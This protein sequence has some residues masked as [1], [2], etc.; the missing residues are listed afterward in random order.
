MKITEF[1][2]E[3]SKKNVLAFIDADQN[4]DLYEEIECEFEEMLPRA[5]EKIQ[6]AALLAFGDISDYG[7]MQDG[8]IVTTALYGINSVGKGLSE[9]STQLFAEGDYLK[10]MLA[11]AMA[12]DYLFQMDQAV[13]STVVEMCR[14]NGYGIVGRLE[15]PQDIPI[16]IQKR[17]FDVT[18]A[19]REIGLKIKES[20]MYDPVKTVCQV[21][22]LDR[23]N[24]R[25]HNEHDCSKCSNLTCRMR[26]IPKVSV[27][28][29]TGG[30]ER[31]IT[32]EKNKSLLRTLQEQQIFLTAVCGGKGSCGKC[33]IRVMEGA[34]GA[35]EADRKCFRKEE[36]EEGYRLACRFYPEED[37]VIELENR[38]EEGFFVVTDQERM[39]HDQKMIRE[40][41]KK[42]SVSGKKEF[43]EYAI[44]VDIGST[45]IAMQLVEPHSGETAEVYTAINRQRAF[46]ADVIS[47]MEASNSG[48]KEELRQSIRKE[49]LTGIE[50]LT[51]GKNAK[52]RSMVI[53]AN[54]TMVH[55]LMGY[56][57]ETLGV[58]PFTPVN[59]DTIHTSFGELFGDMISLAAEG[60]SD[61]ARFAEED[62]FSIMVCPGISTYVGGDILAGMYALGF[63]KMEKIHVLIDLG[64]NGEMAVGNKDRI[65]VASTAAGPA[66]EGGN[67]ICGTG[68]IPGAICGVSLD[69]DRAKIKT[70]GDKAPTGI[71]GTGVIDTVY[72][73]MRAEIIDETGRMEDPYFD[74]GFPLTE[75]T[76][77]GG[78]DIRFYQKDVREIQLA[79]SAVRAGLETLISRYG[80]SYDEIEKIYIAGG[81]GYK[82]DIRKAAGIGLLPEKCISQ[83]A[84]D[85]ENAAPEGEGKIVAVGNSCL[86]GARKCL[87]ETDAVSALQYLKEHAEEVSLSDDKLFQQLYMEHMYFE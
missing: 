33:R 43:G 11:D 52:I 25:F 77:A 54:T 73:L 60:F 40:A 71:C 47:R 75:G 21:Y 39:D 72:E 23:N 86:K 5:Y 55:L 34:G 78:K 79:K 24:S 84:L 61:L 80:T 2:I 42:A 46:G 19:E 37:C 27:L 49:L 13:Q 66:F 20:F 44:A 16:S 4:S 68:S 26:K 7:I 57:C 1:H 29:K 67:I 58:F 83:E 6:P 50:T 62:S 87:S 38:E 41:E 31:K 82:M 12:D 18:D 3:L 63:D 30:Q 10:G 8:E 9:W 65:L 36:L 74:E 81:F 76:D 48:H 17:A 53:G 69:G 51:A 14:E 28:L 15:A 35:T 64:T 85:E 22:I 56:S 59:I 32:A 45:T 70:I